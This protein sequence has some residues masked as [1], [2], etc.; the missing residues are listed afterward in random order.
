M[1]LLADVPD[2]VVLPLGL[3]PDPEFPVSAAVTNAVNSC[4]DGPAPELPV[5][6][7]PGLDVPP[8]SVPRAWPSAVSSFETVVWSLDTC[9]SSVETVW[10]AASQVAW[11]CGVAV[12]ALVQSLW[13]WTRSACCLFWS[14]ES[15]DSS[16]VNVVWSC[17]TVALW[18]LP[19]CVGAVVVVVVV[20]D[21][22]LLGV[23]F[24]DDGDDA[25]DDSLS[26]SSTSFASSA[27]RVDSADE[28][29]SLSAV[30]SSVPRVCPAVT[31]WPAVT[32]TVATCPDTWNEAEASLTGSTLPTT[33]MEVPMSARVTVASR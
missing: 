28:T 14:V 3:A 30:V 25:E 2:G 21:G 7:L 10:R 6:P 1:S 13:A 16:W 23:L 12:L 26:S 18:P 29:A 24:V 19:A 11:P 5:A 8:D 17:V 33:V 20:D 27:A 4:P 22:V 15:V 9:C 31:C 32:L